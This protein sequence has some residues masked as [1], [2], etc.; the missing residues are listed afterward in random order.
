M[1]T[2][3][4]DYDRIKKAIDYIVTQ[5]NRQPS[6]DDIAAHLNLSPY[7]FQRLFRRW[8]G[9]SPKRFLQIQ[10]LQHAKAMLRESLTILDTSNELGL[11]SPARLHD[12]F[13][14]LE[15]ITP[16]EYK[17]GGKRLDLTC[18]IHSTPFG[19][20]LIAV[21]DRGICHLSF[22][23]ENPRVAGMQEIR[24]VW[25]N[26]GITHSNMVTAPYIKAI[27]SRQ[28]DIKTF[29]LYVQGTNFQV[30]VWR[31]LLQIPPGYVMTYGQLSRIIGSPGSARAVGTAI[32]ANP[33]AY[34]IPCH[35]VILASGAIG[36][37]RWGSIRKRAILGWESGKMENQ[38]IE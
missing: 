38:P 5:V 12:H 27:F 19:K 20:A 29:P 30:N 35:R 8:A 17:S 31:A 22:I 25:P 34:L 3:I 9:I 24:R 18:G 37:Y 23:D 13:V 4:N 11:S 6:L 33:I 26:A 2:R 10:T 21:T 16:G 15:A 32:A 28:E 36:K 1:H 14:T 7:H